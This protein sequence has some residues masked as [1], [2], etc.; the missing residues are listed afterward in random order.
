VLQRGSQGDEPNPAQPD[1]AIADKR[2]R[3]QEVIFFSLPYPN[4]ALPVDKPAGSL[5]SAKKIS[6]FF[7]SPDVEN[8]GGKCSRN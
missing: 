3:Q 8:F 5:V 2:K 1:R 7:K 6:G 4:Q